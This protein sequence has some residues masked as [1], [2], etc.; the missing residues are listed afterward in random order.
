MYDMKSDHIHIRPYL[1]SLVLL[2]GILLCSLLPV[3]SYLAQQSEAD[4]ISYAIQFEPSKASDDSKASSPSP[5][6][7]RN[8]IVEE[9]PDQEQP[10]GDMSTPALIK[11]V[12]SATE[13]VLITAHLDVSSFL[14]RFRYLSTDYPLSFIYKVPTSKGLPFPPFMSG[15]AINAP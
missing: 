5:D 15:M 4:L 13:V 9:T 12:I 3:D 2:S 10:S 1:F 11:Q 8:L 7:P 14:Y 6:A